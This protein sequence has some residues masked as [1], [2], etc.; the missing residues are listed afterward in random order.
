MKNPSVSQSIL[1]A[2]GSLLLLGVFANVV[3]AAETVAP[4]V[5]DRVYF[6]DRTTNCSSKEAFHG[7]PGA[8]ELYCKGYIAA[9]TYG[10]VVEI[11]APFADRPDLTHYCINADY[12]AKIPTFCL[13]F[14]GGTFTVI[15]NQ[16]EKI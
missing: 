1:L 12:D 14:D 6:A 5:G 11:D 10:T 2:L 3:G 8:R 7:F 16:K 4:K 15:P 9:K 13:W